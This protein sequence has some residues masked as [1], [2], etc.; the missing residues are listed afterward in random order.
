MDKPHKCPEC[1][2]PFSSVQGVNDHLR[3]VHRQPAVAEASGEQWSVA[4]QMSEGASCSLCGVCFHEEHGYPVVCRSCWKDL[5][6][7]ERREY[8]R[9]T[10]A[11]F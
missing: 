1:H 10:H 2:K 3:D 6:Q 11:E 7:Y 5:S 8:Q 4:D 9:A